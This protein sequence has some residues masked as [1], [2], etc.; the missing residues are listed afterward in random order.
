MIRIINISVFSNNIAKLS[1][2][3]AKEQD[4]KLTALEFYGF[5]A[6]LELYNTFPGFFLSLRQSNITSNQQMIMK[7]KT[8]VFET[9]KHHQKEIELWLSSRCF[10]R[11]P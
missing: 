4:L 7:I 10:V 5:L 9:S 11:T 8:L 2:S 3:S 1:T 6:N